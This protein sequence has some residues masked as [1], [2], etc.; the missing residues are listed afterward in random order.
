MQLI[1]K[2]LSL[3]RPAAGRNHRIRGLSTAELVGIIVIVGILGALG[4]T[5]IAGLVGQAQTNAIAQNANSLNTVAAS[6]IAAGAGFGGAAGDID[7]TS[8]STAIADLN[9]GVVVNNVTYQMSPPISA[10]AIATLASAT[11]SYTMTVNGTPPNATIVFAA[12]AKATVP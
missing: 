1:H 10:A 6:A 11:P 2:L 5:Y 9:A 4:G 3:K 12:G 7:T 8:A